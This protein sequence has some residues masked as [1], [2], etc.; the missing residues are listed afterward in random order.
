MTNFSKFSMRRGVRGGRRSRNRQRNSGV[1]TAR[2]YNTQVLKFSPE[3]PTRNKA[4]VQKYMV[5]LQGALSANAGSIGQL[6]ITPA[7]IAAADQSSYGI[8]TGVRWLYMRLDSVR[9]W[10]CTTAGANSGAAATA[11][12]LTP[13]T[14]T[15]LPGGLDFDPAYASD[16]PGPGTSWARVGFKMPLQ[17]RSEWIST[18]GASSTSTLVV[19]SMGVDP[20]LAP[21]TVDVYGQYIVDCE[22]SFR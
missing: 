9:C 11:G 14:L 7:L 18:T 5:R 16:T 15:L 22:V 1:L 2:D 10:L 19:M 6:N 8:L 17:T 21:A 3:P 20:A 4:P 12:A 13:I